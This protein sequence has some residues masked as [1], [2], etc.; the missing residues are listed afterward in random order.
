[1]TNIILDTDSYKTSHF[2]QYPEGTTG[3]RAYFEARTDGEDIRFFGLQPVLRMLETRITMEMVDEAKQI[4]EAHGLPFPYEGWKRVVEVHDGK[5]PLKVQAVEEGKVIPSHNVLFVVESTDPELYWLVTW[6]ETALS[7]VWYP[8][9]VASR[10]YDLYKFFRDMLD[11]TSENPEQELPFK[12]HDFG[13]RGVS[14]R[15]SAGIGGAAHL[16]NFMGTDTIEAIMWAQQNYGWESMPGFSIPA[17][18]HSTMTTWGEDGEIDAFGNMIE[19]FG[20]GDIFAC[21]SD[22]YS[23]YNAVENLWGDALR[24]GVQEMNAMLVVR[25][26]SGDPL[27][28]VMY[29]LDTLGEKFG[30]TLNKKG[31]KVLN[32][33]RV[34]QGD[35]VTP[36][37]VKRIVTT[38]VGDGWA[39]DN[40]AFG[41]GSGLLQKVN[42]DTHKFAYKVSEAIIN[43]EP[44]PVFKEPVGQPDK[45]SKR[46]QLDLI[47][48]G[49]TYDTID[50]RVVHTDKDSE[51]VTVFENGVVTKDY[52]FEQV[53]KNA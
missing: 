5:I 22:S 34:I 4:V 15:E 47:K 38:A 51:L 19:K 8:T 9:T 2:L 42:R 7:R 29:C 49:G 20:G 43:G 31:F 33:V 44:V 53:R 28:M 13:S 39:V 23:I 18:E 14:S 25:P 11:A 12:L 52:T 37:D 27:D 24:D 35:G 6:F 16:V 10:S 3:L 17:S 45:R 41:M 30:F 36:A 40:L 48:V 50:R 26:D 21:V 32:N 46:G 1:M